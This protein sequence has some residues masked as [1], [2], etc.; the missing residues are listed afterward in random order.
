M[1]K[2]SII[3]PT[4]SRPHLLP[5][6]VESAH[7]AGTDVE[8]IVVDDASVDRTAKVCGELSGIKY[9]RVDRNQGVAGARNVGL[10][11]AEGEYIAFLDDDDLRLPGSLDLQAQNLD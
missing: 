2:I 1:S 8:V 5:R 9:V 10:M 6:A 7:A 11:H 4:H 3:I